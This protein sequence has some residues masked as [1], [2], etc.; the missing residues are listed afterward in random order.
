[1]TDRAQK[2]M[3]EIWEERNSWADTEEKLVAAIIRKTLD[4]C[5]TF[6]AQR[7]NNMS[8]VDKKDLIQLSNE[9]EN[10]T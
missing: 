8:V 1:M 6:V 3:K 2:L 9:L 5:K 10:L 4:N 7:M